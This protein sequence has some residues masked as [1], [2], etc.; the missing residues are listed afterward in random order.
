MT[1]KAVPIDKENALEMTS[2]EPVNVTAVKD[3]TTSV[4]PASIKLRR[5]V[6]RLTSLIPLKVSILPVLRSKTK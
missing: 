5:V 6:A 3:V 1:K 2:Y 4:Q